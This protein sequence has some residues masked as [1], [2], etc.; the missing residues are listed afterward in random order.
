MKVAILQSNYIPWRGYFNLIKE[1]DIFIFH[2]DLQYT[3]NDWRNRNLIRTQSG[4][5]W[6]TIPVGTSEKRKINEVWLPDNAWK[7]K[8]LKLLE[9]SYS[10]TPHWNYAKNLMEFIYLQDQS[11]NLSEFNSNIIIEISK[12]YL[13]FKTT[14]RKS[15]EWKLESRKLSRVLELLTQVGATEYVSGPSGKNYL[16]YRE[17]KARGINLSYIDYSSLQ[18]YKQNFPNF[19][20]NVSVLDL[21]FNCGESSSTLLTSTIHS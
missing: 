7:E 6:L 19:E 1:V 3:K 21:I 2:D 18:P 17:F 5:R 12:N 11:K 4:L 13:G 15:T 14:F 9:M 10:K 16:D 20:G 8:H